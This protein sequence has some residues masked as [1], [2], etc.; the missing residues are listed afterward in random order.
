MPFTLAHAAA[1]LPF[2][3][4]P[5]VPLALVAGAM[6][7]DLPYFLMLPPSRHGRFASILNGV[8][9]HD[10]TQILSVGLPLALVLAGFLW[11]VREPV[12]WALPKSWVPANPARTGRRPTSA[13][14]VLWTFYSLMLGLLTHL[15]WDSFTHSSGWVVQQLPF[16]G[17]SPVGSIPLFRILQHGSSIVG[18]GILVIWYLK[19]RKTSGTFE[20]AGELRSRY[21]RTLMLAM[22]LLVP[23]ETAVF[24]GLGQDVV[25]VVEDPASAEVFL[26]I[27]IRQSGAGAMMA[28]A[29]YGVAWHVIAKIR[30]FHGV[31]MVRS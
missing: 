21:V 16:L 2:V 10:F 23:A 3:R 24:V 30:E 13:R 1:V 6:A 25:P 15:V 17:V 31:G 8:N 12:R 9:S 5:L 7:P 28:L 20:N 27:V 22:F 26:Q 29:A 4:Q 11:L 14:I 18:L 19:R